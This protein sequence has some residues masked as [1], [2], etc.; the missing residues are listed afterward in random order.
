M[1]RA[2]RPV[3]H[4]VALSWNVDGPAILPDGR[5]L[6]GSPSGWRS[7]QDKRPNDRGDRQ[8]HRP[9]TPSGSVPNRDGS[10]AWVVGKNLGYSQASK[11]VAA[12]MASARYFR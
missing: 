4:P 7:Q 11:A 3:G 1:K 9:S 10:H 2:R 8:T 12:E 5:R 6:A